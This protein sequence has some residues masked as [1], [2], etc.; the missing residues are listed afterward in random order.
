[1]HFCVST[2]RRYE[3]FPVPRNTSLNWFIPAFVKRR[4]GSSWGMTGA[5]GTTAWPCSLKN[6][7]KLFRISR[8]VISKPVETQSDLDF[9]L[10]VKCDFLKHCRNAKTLVH[11]PIINHSLSLRMDF[12]RQRFGPCSI[13]SQ[14]FHELSDDLFEGVDLIVVEDDFCRRSEDTRLNSSHSQISYAVF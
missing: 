5:L 8:D 4:V 6:E 7:R 11:H 12:P 1:M 10:G 2:A 14:S 3:R 13:A 9:D